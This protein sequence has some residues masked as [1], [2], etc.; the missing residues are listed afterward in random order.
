MPPLAVPGPAYP[1]A[2]WA[3]GRPL[4]Q[5]IAEALGKEP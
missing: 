2:T 5:A 4:E 1:A 3:H